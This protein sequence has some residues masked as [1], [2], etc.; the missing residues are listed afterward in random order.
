MTKGEMRL[1]FSIHVWSP[2]ARSPKFG[3]G[4]REIMD[5]RNQTNE[6][7]SD[8]SF[9]LRG[10]ETMEDPRQRLTTSVSTGELERRWKAAREVM[11]EQKIDYLIMRNDE[12]FIGGYTR[13]FIDMPARHSIRHRH[14]RTP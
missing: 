7:A 12:E 14:F 9:F 1:P 2:L 11:K 13:W 10:I 8:Q 6:S 5:I 3:T 4:A